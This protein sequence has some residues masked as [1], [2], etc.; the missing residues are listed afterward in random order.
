MTI[1]FKSSSD[2]FNPS[3]T[4]INMIP[5]DSS[6]WTRDGEASLFSSGRVWRLDGFEVTVG[7]FQSDHRPV[8]HRQLFVSGAQASVL[9]Q[10]ALNSGNTDIPPTIAALPAQ[11]K[12]PHPMDAG[13]SVPGSVFLETIPLSLSESAGAV[14]LNC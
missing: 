11:R 4:S 14:R 5:I 10:P 6:S 13:F 12:T 8:V 7:V 9:L 2:H 3:A 1:N